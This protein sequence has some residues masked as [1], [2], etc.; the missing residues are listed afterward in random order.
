MKTIHSPSSRLIPLGLALVLAGCGT[1]PAPPPAPAVTPEGLVKVEDARADL[2]YRLPAA[3]L[4][5]YTKV[6]LLE[7]RIAFRKNWQNEI[8]ANSDMDRRPISDKDVQ[9][10]LDNGRRLLLEEFDRVLTKGGYTVVTE[11]G[12][13]V[14][15]IRG[16][17]LDLD[18]VAPD[19]NNMQRAW[20]DI[21]TNGSGSATL[22]VELYDSVTR[23][24][25]ARAF[26]QKSNANEDAFTWSTPRN[27]ATNLADARTALA[28]WAEMLVEGLNRAKTAKKP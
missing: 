21:H 18:V 11:F 17:I 2:V 24:L 15:A 10:I 13:D 3:R 12:P 5:G 14:L 9:T 22:C 26:D 20:A 6:A 1:P 28:D 25:L 7:P 4:D 19:P 16:S 23:Q 27:R 8:N